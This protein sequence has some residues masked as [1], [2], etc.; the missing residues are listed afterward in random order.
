MAYLQA[1]AGIAR[2]GVT[3][4]GWTPP[5][6]KCTINGTDRTSVVLRENWKLTMRADGAPATFEFQTK[7]ITPVLGQDVRVYFATPND[8][9]FAGTLLQ[10]QSEPQA[11]TST[12][13]KW[14]CTAVDY[15]WLLNRYDQVLRK[16][17]NRGVG[18]IAADLLASYTNGGFRVGYCPSSLGN[19]DMTFRF[20]TVWGALQ[21]LAKAVDAFLELTPERIVN[22]YQT[23]PEAALATVTQATV[24]QKSGLFADDLT[25]VRT[26]T[27]FEGIASQ[28]TAAVNA[29]ASTIPVA[30]LSPF[31]ASGGTVRHDVSLITYSGIDTASRALTG[32][33]GILDDIAVN[34]EIAVIATDVDASAT[35]ALATTLGGGLSGQATHYLKDGRLSLAEATA[36]AAADTS[37][38]GGALQDTSFTYKTPQRYVRAGRSVTLNI[39]APLTLSGTG[40]LQVVTLEPYG[41][42]GGTLFEARQKVHVSTFTRTLTDLL[43]QLPG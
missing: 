33:S 27:I 9:L 15:Q 24:L 23:Y 4:A 16:Y 42:I 43:K 28:A 40:T 2:S 5:S 29:G 18:T 14:Q 12:L 17:V 13:L 21:R 31:S 1:R 22:I 20:D 38:L 32:C 30:D 39:T 26:R 11:D 35:T 7:T 8:Y 36:R 3:Y 41:A 19:L 6:V 34:D 25:Q 10:R 37:R